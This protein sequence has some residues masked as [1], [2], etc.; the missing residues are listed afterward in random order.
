MPDVNDQFKQFAEQVAQDEADKANKR[1]GFT[2]NYEKVKWTGLEQGKIKIIR[3]LG[4]VPN[5]GDSPYTSRVVRIAYVID[6]KGKRMKVVLPSQEKD[7]QYLMWR[8][9]NRVMEPSWEKVGDKNVKSY[10]VQSKHPD[11]FNIVAYNGLPESNVKRKYGLEGKGWQGREFLLMN[12]I[13]R[14]LTSWHKENK[15]SV[16]LSK[17]VTL[18]TDKN[19]NPIEY[20]E[21]G[22]PSFGFI[23][24]LASSLFRYYGDWKGYDIGVEKTGQQST[25]LI[26]KNASKHLEEI[27][28]SL[29]GLVV[30]G[31]IT[32]EE[33]E[34]EMYDLDKLYGVTTYTKLFNRLRLTI[35]KI[36]LALGTRYSDELKSMAD[37]EAKDRE[38][39]KARQDQEEAMLNIKRSIIQHFSRQKGQ[40]GARLDLNVLQLRQM[41]A[42]YIL[43]MSMAGI[44]R[45]RQNSHIEVNYGM[46]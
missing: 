27:P 31:P 8:I 15:H 16:L 39:L 46:V 4:G 22:V 35:A 12:C 21:E 45:V 5:S 14:A 42:L 24:I 30:D 23:N 18:D 29:K 28:E 32:K 9:V 13:D 19:G 10:P 34:Y 17:K 41:Q 20:V 11:V 40:G 1:G 36:D 25:P 26:V 43:I 2:A 33:S 3:A 6:D 38:A 44:Y 37:A 7:P